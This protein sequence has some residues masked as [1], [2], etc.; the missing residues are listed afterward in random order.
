MTQ[1]VGRIIKTIQTSVVDAPAD[2]EILIAL[3]A[4]IGGHPNH[5]IGDRY[6][7]LKDLGRDLDNPAGV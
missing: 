6:E 2:D 3:G 1:A 4:S 5:R 7:D